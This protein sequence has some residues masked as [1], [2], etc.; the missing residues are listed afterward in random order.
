M[1]TWLRVLLST[2]GA[3][4]DAVEHLTALADAEDKLTKATSLETL[5]YQ[6]GLVDGIRKVLFLLKPPQTKGSN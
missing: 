1:R 5:H 4:A 6:R 3:V 2:D